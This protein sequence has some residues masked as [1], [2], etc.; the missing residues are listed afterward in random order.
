MLEFIINN[1]IIFII[2]GI[3]LLLGLFGYIFDR[4]K[5]EQYRKEILNEDPLF[6]NMLD[7]EPNVDN[8][9][10]PVV[11]QNENV[12][13]TPVEYAPELESPDVAPVVEEQVSVDPLTGE[14]QQ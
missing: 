8:T 4:R 1:Y 9:A 11:V 2:A 5:Y 3:V 14:I 7:S 10:S 13:E 12:D 6:D